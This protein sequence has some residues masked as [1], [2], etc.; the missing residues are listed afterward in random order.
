MYVSLS[1]LLSLSLGE[2]E[3]SSVVRLSFSK[4]SLSQR[5]ERFGINHVVYVL[6]ITCIHN[7]R[8]TWHKQAPE[9][10]VI[11]SFC[12]FVAINR[13]SSTLFLLHFFPCVSSF[14]FI[15]SFSPPIVFSR[16]LSFS[17]CI[18]LLWFSFLLF[19]RHSFFI[20]LPCEWSAYSCS[21][22]KI[23]GSDASNV[24][25]LI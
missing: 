7:F 10:S 22:T 1:I 19:P 16:C 9:S 21:G 4:T 15:F 5:K 12:M 2:W 11:Y 8:F 18:V 6:R 24:I 13:L 14:T 25:H 17:I 23:N 3:E 20:F